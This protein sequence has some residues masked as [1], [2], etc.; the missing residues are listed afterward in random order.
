MS[1]ILENANNIVGIVDGATGVATN[2][3]AAAQQPHKR[4]PRRGR[5]GRGGNRLENINNAVG[6]VDGAT[7]IAT[8]IY[9]A[10]H[11]ARDF[12]E[13]EARRVRHN[14]SKTLERLN[15]A[16]GFADTASGVIANGVM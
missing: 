14:W 10:T 13:L 6:I 15:D 5:T 16:A 8:N 3:A 1:K 9:G 12:D 11:Q 7:G 4:E 2:I